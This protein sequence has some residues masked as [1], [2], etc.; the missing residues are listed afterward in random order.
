MN[1]TIAMHI[2]A[3]KDSEDDYRVWSKH[4]LSA[5]TVRGYREILSGKKI[6]SLITQNYLQ[7]LIKRKQD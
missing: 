6:K 2:I 7:I 5:A 4:F 1:D 3:F